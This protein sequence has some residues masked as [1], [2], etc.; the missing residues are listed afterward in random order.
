ML[1]DKE[2]TFSDIIAC[3]DELLVRGYGAPDAVTGIGAS[4]GGL[5][6]AVVANRRPALFHALVLRVSPSGS[7]I[8][9]SIPWHIP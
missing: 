8:P 9:H 5:A 6:L 3:V 1:L 7:M 4:A 2:R